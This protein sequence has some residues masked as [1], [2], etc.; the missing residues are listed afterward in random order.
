MSS[1]EMAD[2]LGISKRK[3]DDIRAKTN[4]RVQDL[5]GKD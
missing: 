3:M 1:K 4:T 5:K 2:K